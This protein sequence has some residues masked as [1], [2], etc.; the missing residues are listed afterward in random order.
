MVIGWLGQAQLRYADFYRNF[1]RKESC[2]DTNH[3]D[4]SRQTC[5]RRSNKIQLVTMHEESRRESARRSRRNG[6][7]A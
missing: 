6:I 7:W 3:L 4:M 2:G 1:P 5:L